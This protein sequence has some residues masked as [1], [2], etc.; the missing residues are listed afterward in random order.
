MSDRRDFSLLSVKDLRRTFGV[1]GGLNY[2]PRSSLF[3]IFYLYLA[4]EDWTTRLLYLIHFGLTRKRCV[5]YY[6]LLF[7]LHHPAGPRYTRRRLTERRR[8]HHAHELLRTKQNREM[9]LLARVLLPAASSGRR[10]V[11]LKRGGTVTATSSPSKGRRLNGGAVSATSFSSSVSSAS[12]RRVVRAEAAS[13]SSDAVV[14]GVRSHELTAKHMEHTEVEVDAEDEGAAVI[15]A[16]GTTNSELLVLCAVL[17]NAMYDTAAYAYEGYSGI[18][19]PD[20]EA[21]PLQNAFGLVFTVFCGWYFLR[22]VKKRGNRA[23]E[24]RV[25][26][27]LPVRDKQKNKKSRRCAPRILFSPLSS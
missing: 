16:S 18:G 7:F 27:S 22:V 26:N 5:Q 20:D 6:V 8:A 3:R 11:S 25:A 19:V 2:R 24:F 1:H 12:T 9:S 4:L 13:R 14:S 23:K 17:T 21:T 10:H 15:E